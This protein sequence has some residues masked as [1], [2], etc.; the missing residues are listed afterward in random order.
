MKK[1]LFYLFFCLLC[2]SFVNANNFSEIGFRGIELSKN[3]EFIEFEGSLNLD[4]TQAQL[5]DKT[6]AGD[7]R[8][9]IEL[10]QNPSFTTYLIV[11]PDFD[12]YFDISQFNCNIYETNENKIVQSGL[13]DALEN[14][15]L[16]VN[17]TLNYTFVDDGITTY[18]FSTNESLNY[19]KNTKQYEV[20]QNSPCGITSNFPTL[21][22]TKPNIVS[23]T[24]SK[25]IINYSSQNSNFSEKFNITIVFDED[26]DQ[27]IIP[28]IFFKNL[29]T[30]HGAN[31]NVQTSEITNSDFII[32]NSIWKDTKTFI[33]E[34]E[35]NFT[36]FS[37][38]IDTFSNDNISLNVSNSEDLSGNTLDEKEFTDVSKLIKYYIRTFVSTGFNGGSTSNQEYSSYFQIMNMSFEMI[39]T[40]KTPEKIFELNGNPIS[41]FSR[42]YYF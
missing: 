25:S 28:H 32:T 23:L 4:L 8:S 19:N 38:N 2:V 20:A 18:S 9:L 11:E 13:E 42:D 31:S 36:K 17:S 40:S 34:Y 29:S 7:S 27:L 1:T 16:I 30:V 33:Q 24:S 5:Y 14:I 22:K 41:K 21:D 26:M 15:T 3:Y 12:D 10:K 35:I 37:N 39:N 6:G